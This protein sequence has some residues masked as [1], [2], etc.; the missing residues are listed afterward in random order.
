MVTIVMQIHG[1][2][3]V[4]CTTKG[5]QKG[6]DLLVLSISHLVF[7]TMSEDSTGEQLPANGEA[8][9]ETKKENM[10]DLEK[11]IIRQIEVFLFLNLLLV[12]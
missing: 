4:H 5:P 9:N 12:L 3:R 11:K 7:R 6:I 2:S 1:I 10:T 8:A